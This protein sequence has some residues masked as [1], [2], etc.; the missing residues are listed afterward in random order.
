[1]ERILKLHHPTGHPYWQRNKFKI[2]MPNGEFFDV[3]KFHED[4]QE[5]EISVTKFGLTI[6]RFH[7][8]SGGGKQKVGNAELIV[9]N[10]EYDKIEYIG[11]PLE[12]SENLKREVGQIDADN[13]NVG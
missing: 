4:Y 9:G 10:L 11:E 8:S 7:C 5:Y 3:S 6:Q 2:E 1:M 13:Y 12:M